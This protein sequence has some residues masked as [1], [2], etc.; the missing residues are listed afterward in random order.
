MNTNTKKREQGQVLI[1]LVGA[2]VALFGFTALAI[3]GGMMWSDR[4]HAQ[5]AADAAAL[6]GA[7]QLAVN[8]SNESNIID[9]AEGR[10]EDNGYANSIPGK[11]VVV[12]HP[13][14]APSVFAGNGNY[15]QVIITSRVDTSLIHFVYKGD[16]INQVES[17]SHVTP[18]YHGP[19]YN[20]N[21]LVSL[22]P[23]VCPGF[24]ASGSLTIN[25]TDGGIFVN[26]NC[27][28][29][30]NNYAVGG[31]S[32]KK[33]ITAPSLT[34][35]G[36]VDPSF[37]TKDVNIGKTNEGSEAYP[38]PPG[39]EEIGAPK[40][41]GVAS[42]D[43]GS[44]TY[45]VEP[46]KNGS[47]IVGGIPKNFNGRLNPGIY[48]VPASGFTFDAGANITANNVMFYITGDN[49]CDWTWNGGATIVFSAP[50]DENNK[51]KGMLIYIDTKD[52]DPLHQ[53]ANKPMTINGNNG[54]SIT[55]TVYA[56]TCYVK[57]VGTEEMKFIGQLIGY[58]FTNSGDSYLNIQYDGSLVYQGD[59]SA[60]V[61]LTK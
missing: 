11:T 20:G 10:A 17:V 47:R 27:Q 15:I 13:P 8:P 31:N 56:P 14:V 9:K 29:P 59:I 18:G 7:Y 58:V 60:K 49:P 25:I 41:D 61:S 53:P 3:D 57:K 21:A 6:A 4:R 38:Y 1:I 42:F 54:S 34:V 52:F 50:T 24:D 37:V 43:S 51:Y 12:N 19:L 32:T 22:A 45:S 36:K 46:N 39:I 5:N 35:V 44:N 33:E 2:I 16:V 28:S 30:P 48:C 55:G 40:C 23:D 26:S